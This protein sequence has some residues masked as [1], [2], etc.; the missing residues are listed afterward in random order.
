VHKEEKKREASA[1]GATEG[2]DE[3]MKG[4]D[5]DELPMI[6]ENEAEAALA[7]EELMMQDNEE[8]SDDD[9]PAIED[10]TEEFTAKKEF[11]QAKVEKMEAATGRALD[12]LK[13]KVLD[14]RGVEVLPEKLVDR[15]DLPELTPS[16]ILKNEDPEA[17]EECFGS[18]SMYSGR[19]DL[20]VA[21]QSSIQHSYTA[22]SESRK[23]EEERQRKL[24]ELHDL[25]D[26]EWIFG[27]SKLNFY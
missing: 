2:S 13:K 1:T 22:E 27:F 20:S 9:G 6:E 14:D 15:A 26:D 17:W 21:E 25:G 11:D 8:E 12:G 4:A 18:K 5:D 7:E 16:Q 3:T 19:D 23:Q 24:D 10:V